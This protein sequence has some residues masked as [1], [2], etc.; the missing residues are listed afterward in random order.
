MEADFPTRIKC[1]GIRAE[2]SD[3]LILHGYGIESSSGVSGRLPSHWQ[4]VSHSR[5]RQE[6]T[7]R[8]RRA[9]QDN[10]SFISTSA[11]VC[12]CFFL[13]CLCVFQSLIVFVCVSLSHTDARDGTA[14]TWDGV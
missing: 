13:L 9:P 5:C 12:A 6:G 3:Q 8:Y 1:S 11:A 4:H 7:E 14:G 10:E 2:L